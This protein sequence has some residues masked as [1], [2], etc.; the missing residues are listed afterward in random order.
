MNKKAVLDTENSEKIPV[1]DNV[2]KKLY[3]FSR[4][5]RNKMWA[6]QK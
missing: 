4:D 1:G 5:S 6:S 2:F 3:C